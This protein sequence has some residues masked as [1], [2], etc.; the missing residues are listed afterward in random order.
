ML[1]NQ[2]IELMPELKDTAAW[3]SVG[4]QRRR[5]DFG[6]AFYRRI[7]LGFLDDAEPPV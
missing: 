5:H 6:Q 4:H 2:L 7:S 1:S 3:P